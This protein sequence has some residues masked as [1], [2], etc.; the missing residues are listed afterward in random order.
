MI[1]R[2]ALVALL[3]ERSLTFGDFTL[4]SGTRSTYYIDARRTT[5]SAEGQALIGPLGLAAIRGAGWTPRAVGGLTMG[6]DPIAYA[7]ARAS[8]DEPPRVDAFSVRKESKEHGTRRRIEGNFTPGTPV[9]VVE[10]VIT[11]G[12]STLKAIEAVRAEGGDVQGV[13]ALVDR[14]QGGRKAIEATGT[15]VVVLTTTTDLGVD[16]P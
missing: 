4:A 1:D 6:A 8:V 9:V 5:M 11:S 12:G 15:Q 16:R 10:D 13:L 3:R 2:A 14:E 7:I